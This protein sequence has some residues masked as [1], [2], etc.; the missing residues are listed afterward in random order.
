M[1]FGLALFM[2][3]VGLK[4][5]G[6]VVEALTSVGPAMIGAGVAVTLA[7]VAVGFVVGRYA[8][9]LNPALLLGSITGAMTSTPSLNVLTEISRSSVP[10]LGYAGTYTFANVLLTFAGT[11]MMM[12]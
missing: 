5:G 12:L 10:A 7:P 9:G 3:E 4:A 8:L 1:N 6:G 2:A 11:M